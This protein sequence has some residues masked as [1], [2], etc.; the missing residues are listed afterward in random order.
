MPAKTESQLLIFRDW[1]FRYRP[2]RRG[3]AHLLV[4][5][6]GWMGD[7]NSMWFFTRYIPR[8]YA[9]LSPRALFS[10]PDGGNSWREMKPGIHGLPTLEGLRPAAES[11]LK[12]IDDWSAAQQMDSG[13]FDLMGFSQGAAFTMVLALLYPARV[14][15]LAVLSGFLPNGV[16]AL[17][18]AR[19][20]AGKRVLVTHG[21]QDDIVPMEQAHRSVKLL[22]ESGTKV[23]YYESMVGHKVAKECVYEL[24]RFSGKGMLLMGE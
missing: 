18:A 13:Q 3:T 7:E 15:S 16:E 9:I 14:C 23:V 8:D 4:L 11:L 6:H 10:V 5:L 17:L 1:T 24:D 2:A 20:L 22:K 21:T 19:P 12:F